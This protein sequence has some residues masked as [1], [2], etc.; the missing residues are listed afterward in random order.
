MG[1]NTMFGKFGLPVLLLFTLCSTVFA[2]NRAEYNRAN[3]T[4]FEYKIPMRDGVKLFTAV[5]QPTDRSKEYPI[6]LLRT[7]YSIGPYGADNYK[8]SLGPHEA[9]EKEGFIFVFQDVRGK[10][11]SEGQFVNMRPHHPNKKRDR[12]IDESTDTYDTI[13]WL[14]DRIDGHNGK[15]GQWG[16]SYPGFYTSAG[17]IDSHPALKAVSPQAPI[18]DWFW[19]DFHRHGAFILSMGFNFFSTHGQEREAPRCLIYKCYHSHDPSV[20]QHL[21]V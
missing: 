16:V 2:E 18:G 11:M 14:I 17:A 9:F 4:K 10:F 19:D 7:P 6:L 3:Y 5:Y 8:G 13:E 20:G 12:D 15:V 1:E 21:S